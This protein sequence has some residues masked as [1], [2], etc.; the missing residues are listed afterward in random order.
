MSVLLFLMMKSN[1]KLIND[2]QLYH[3]VYLSALENIDAIA[4]VH[5]NIPHKPFSKLE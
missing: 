1:G 3:T 5:L 2:H 4:N